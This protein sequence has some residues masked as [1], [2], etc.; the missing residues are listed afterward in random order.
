MT[1][2]PVAVVFVLL[3][4]GCACGG[5]PR[6]VRASA[7][8][9][10]PVAAPAPPPPAPALQ[11]PP[12]APVP[13]PP[14]S[15]ASRLGGSAGFARIAHATLEHVGR[16][17]RVSRMLRGPEPADIEARF[18]AL[19]C[20]AAGADDCPAGGPSLETEHWGARV[21]DRQYDAFLEDLVAAMGEIGI[22]EVEQNELL[23]I[24]GPLRLHVVHPTGAAA[25]PLTPTAPR[26]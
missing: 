2:R 8:E 25:A 15:L 3:L 23:A 13:P 9:A 5:R 1:V 20:R 19:L 17:R 21:T 18:S 24:V 7:P 26:R 22:G 6:P 4:T 10:A 11:P 14:P 16:D 12:D